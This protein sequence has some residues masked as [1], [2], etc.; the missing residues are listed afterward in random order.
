[1]V[2]AIHKEKIGYFANESGYF[3]CHKCLYEF[4]VTKDTAE[5]C[6]ENEIK[7]Y[8]KVCLQDLRQLK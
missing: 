8:G 3:Y 2:I 1:M 6:Q 4:K 7:D 5:E